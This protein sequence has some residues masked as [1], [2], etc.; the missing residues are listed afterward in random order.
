MS[1]IPSHLPA[2]QPSANLASLNQSLRAI[3]AGARPAIQSPASGDP[4]EAGSAPD[5]T[6]SESDA[7]A[8]Q[9]ARQNQF[10][11]LLDPAEAGAA[12]TSAVANILSNP[13]AALAAQGSLD[14]E[15]VRQL[16]S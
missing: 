7:A 10:A 15:L 3:S 14:P 16:A 2:L 13:A 11:A 12:N 9:V 5:A 8:I 6:G 4:D 1:T